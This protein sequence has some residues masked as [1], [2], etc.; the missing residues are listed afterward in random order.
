MSKPPVRRAAARRA[1][2]PARRVGGRRLAHTNIRQQALGST[3]ENK[4][5]LSMKPDFRAFVMKAVGTPSNYNK[6]NTFQIT[7]TQPGLQVYQGFSYANA[8][9][10]Q[11]IATQI[12]LLNAIQYIAPARFLLENL[13]MS[14]DFQN[15]T[16]VP[17]TL[18][19]YVVKPKRDTWYVNPATGV[20]GMV[21]T[22]INGNVYPWNG[23]PVSAIQQ[24]YN[25]QINATSGGG[26]YL[27]PSVA[28]TTVD[29]F[30][31]YYRIEHHTEVEM[32]QGG[33]HRF[34]L[35]QKYD[36]VMDG[37]I[38]G[39]SG[40]TALKG[41]TGWLMFRAVGSPVQD[42]T[43]GGITTT[44]PVSISCIVT[45]SFRFTQILSAAVGSTDVNSLGGTALD[46][47]NTINP[48]SGAS[49]AVVFS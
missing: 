19:I 44:C 20:P 1:A 12:G 16:S 3:T 17:Q 7:N 27:N 13:H 10:L 5:S 38:Y 15:R 24:G 21:F 46:V 26:A 49:A 47:Y 39:N 18:H 42:T 41:I 2:V 32:A 4:L 22:S 31:E 29:L 14:W 9:E 28:P 8:T 25:A 48:G 33:V 23:D 34:E 37:S 40:L 43:A 11:N 35:N 30:N 6:T 45:K 36:K